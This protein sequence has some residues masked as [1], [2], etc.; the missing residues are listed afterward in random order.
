VQPGDVVYL[1]G[2]IQSSVQ[3]SGGDVY[4][5]LISYPSESTAVFG[6]YDWSQDIVGAGQW[7]TFAIETTVPNL[8][9]DHELQLQAIVKGAS[10]TQL[11][12]AQVT[13]LNMTQSGVLP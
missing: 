12:L 9:S 10:G 2:R 3:A 11:K 4:Y 7:G 1:A 6:F 8:G 5:R 13:V